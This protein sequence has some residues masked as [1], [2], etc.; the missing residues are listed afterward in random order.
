VRDH[1]DRWWPVVAVGAGILGGALVAALVAVGV[2]AWGAA[3]GIIGATWPFLAIGAAVAGLVAGLIWAYNNW[4]WFKN[5]VD[6]A[7]VAIGNLLGWLGP[8]L[9]DALGF[10]GT[11]L[12]E[13]MGHLGELKDWLGPKLGDA[14][15]FIGEKIG[16]FLGLLGN[17]RDAFMRGL[18]VVHGWFTALS[19]SEPIKNIREEIGKLGNWIQT[20]LLPFVHDLATWFAEHL[21]PAARGAG[22]TV[23]TKLSPPLTAVGSF[24]SGVLIPVL[25]KVGG[26][27]KDQLEA[28]LRSAG[29]F[30]TG[31][32]LPTL[33]RLKDWLGEQIGKAFQTFGDNLHKATDFIGDMIGKAKDLINWLG[34]LKDK[35]GSIKDAAGSGI[36]GVLGHLPG[37]AAGTD[38]APGGPAWVGEGREAEVVIGPHL[39][40]LP[41]GSAVIPVSRLPR[42]TSSGGKTTHIH[43]HIGQIVTAAP[44]G[45]TLMRQLEREADF[46]EKAYG[47]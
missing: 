46:L 18:E 38:S 37:F 9:G 40:D 5:A 3:A 12:G 34:Q 32:V 2:A 33:G 13:L 28:R 16:G 22:D 31:T 4:G 27:I 29:S 45:A 1:M 36:G 42:S 44:D 14:F 21:L 26:F 47:R 6:G 30:I 20:Q 35:L 7:R 24:I 11:H 19:N 17:L 43:L 39:M 23:K 41:R 10:L 8:K 15:G 25:G